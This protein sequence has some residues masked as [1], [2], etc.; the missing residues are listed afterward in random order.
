MRLKAGDDAPDFSVMD[1]SG[2]S[3]RLSDFNEQDVLLCF[4]R[5]AGCPFCNLSLKEVT[6]FYRKI[7]RPDFTVIAFFQSP[8]ESVRRM[9]GRINPPFPLVADPERKV[10]DLYGIESS[11]AGALHS[12]AH[13]GRW[14]S[15]T[16]QGFPQRKID[17]DFYLMPA[18]FLVCPPR[19]VALAHYWKSFGDKTP[20]MEIESVLENRP[21]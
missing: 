15:A 8:P 21:E 9:P 13:A 6:A 5:Y 12:I 18:Q 3:V 1:I 20:F 16:A 19:L 10:Y 17:G 7:N 4:Y 14:L 2:K 11:R